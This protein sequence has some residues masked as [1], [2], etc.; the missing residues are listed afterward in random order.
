MWE[1]VRGSYCSLLQQANFRFILAAG[2]GNKRRFI[3][4]NGISQK[5]GENI[6][7]ALPDLLAFTGCGSVS[8]LS[9]K[10]K[11]SAIKIIL[12]QDE[13]LCETMKELGQS[14]TSF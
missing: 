12:K 7:E 3:D 11:Q 2:T 6:C 1:P 8:L 5:Y 13:R 9:G 14:Y 10:G 4:I